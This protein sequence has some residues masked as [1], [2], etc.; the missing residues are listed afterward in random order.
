MEEKVVNNNVR[1]RCHQFHK[2]CQVLFAPSGDL[3]NNLLG[4]FV[5]DSMLE[6]N[7]S[8]NCVVPLFFLADSHP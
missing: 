2:F 8:K 6:A 3:I 1:E 5:S 4:K 7:H